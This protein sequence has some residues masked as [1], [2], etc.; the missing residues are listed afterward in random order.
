M[1]LFN[2]GISNLTSPHK[3]HK[4][5]MTPMQQ[6]YLVMNVSIALATII[7]L[8]FVVGQKILKNQRYTRLIAILLIL[9]L[10]HSIAGGFMYF[11]LK[12]SVYFGWGNWIFTIVGNW[13]LLML[14]ISK[15]ELLAIFSP[16]APF[17]N[18]NRVYGA[19]LFF[20]ILQVIATFPSYAY[21]ALYYI[22]MDLN[23]GLFNL[24]MI[25]RLILLSG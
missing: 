11:F 14:L 19:K 2:N 25:V 12:N 3:Y 21:P 15:I 22:V 20:V 9:S 6:I 23:R 16:L 5:K 18:A 7:A 24:F 1:Q 17:W 8:F 13:T 10:L 4:P